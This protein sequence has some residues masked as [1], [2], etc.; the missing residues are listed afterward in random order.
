[1]SSDKIMAAYDN[2]LLG[3]LQNEGGLEKFLDV[4]FGFLCRRTDF[5]RNMDDPK[6]KFG[7]PP[8]VA[9]KIILSYFTKYKTIVDKMEAE[10][11]ERQSKSKE[12]T[13]VAQIVEIEDPPPSEKET[14]SEVPA[15]VKPKQS[16]LT[17]P[18]NATNDQTVFQSNP[19]SYNGAIRDR[20]Q[21]SQNYDDV[22]VKIVVEKSVVKARQ[23]KVEIQRKHL[24]VCV[25]AN[26]TAN[27]ET[28]I[29]GELQ[30]EV[31]KEESMWS[32]ESGKNIQITLTKFK[33][34]WWTMLVAGE[35]EIDIQKIAPERSMEDMDTE[36]KSVINKLQFDEKQKRLGLPQSHEMKVHEMLKKGWD[37]E[38]SPFKGQE[39]DPKMFN[40]SP[41]A[42][43][44]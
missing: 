7:F 25:K 6:Q 38:G 19:D 14:T 24:K 23:V 11:K 28:I 2:T 8:G 12:L 42:V 35:D 26:D 13:E 17:K 34:I 31:N 33:N 40:I 36:E 30:H 32:L 21:W 20:Y 27:Y 29:D 5:F 39:F 41:G 15:V 18:T 22:D 44:Q 3:I 37:A 4:I 10:N 9:E 16:T 43:E 1:M